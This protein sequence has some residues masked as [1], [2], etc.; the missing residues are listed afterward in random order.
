[1]PLNS[2]FHLVIFAGDILASQ[3]RERKFMELYE[4]LSSSSS[5][6]YRYYTLPEL[7]G[8]RMSGTTR[9]SLRDRIR[10]TA[11]WLICLLVHTFSVT[12]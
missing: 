10:M 12:A 11:R 1:M 6:L 8:R 3:T 2:H 9:T 7:G 5:V 4:K